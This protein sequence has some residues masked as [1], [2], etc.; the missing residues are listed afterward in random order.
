MA[1]AAGFPDGFLWG[2]ATAAYQIEGAVRA[3]GRG[4]S[5]WDT[6]SHTPGKVDGGDTGDV[7]CDHYHRWRQDVTLMRELGLRAYRFSV[8]WPRV[9]PEGARR[10]N[11]PG[12]DFYRRLVDG[13]LDAGVTPMLTLYHWDLP[14]ALQDRGGWASRATVDAFA[15][16]ADVVSRALA[17]RVPLWITHN[18][19]WVVTHLGH[20]T[21][22]H[23]PGVTDP[24]VGLQV[25]HHLLR[26]HGQAV[27]ALRANGASQVGI[28]LNLSPVS[29]ASGRDQDAAAAQRADG[30]LNRWFLDPVL[31][32]R[33]PADLW[34]WFATSGITPEVRD[35]DLEAI[36]QPVDFLGVNYYFRTVATDDP[37]GLVGYRQ[38]DQ[39]GKHT[40]MGWEV[41]PQGLERLLT[42]LQRDY[43]PPAL[44]VTENGAAFD[45]RVDADGQVRDDR[46]V[47]YLDGHFRAAAQAIAAGVPLRGYFV[48]SLLDNFEWSYG[49]AKRFGIVHVDYATQRRTVKDS[50]RFVAAVARSN[51]LP[52]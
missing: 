39:P 31:R 26:S 13:L 5:I 51:G 12:L 42:R 32:G 20:V 25:A 18:E 17:D 24:S 50:G 29:P 14:Q 3:D 1:T 36:A 28:T 38:V 33:Y 30:W 47:A 34:E 7:A 15:A 41:C 19:P 49:Y 27:L 4:P 45:D 48:W 22:Q 2:T 44:Y 46:R 43:A 40:A 23:A 21:G 16:Y 10:V 8:A 6:F 35:G 11:Q 52:G 9:L 37:A